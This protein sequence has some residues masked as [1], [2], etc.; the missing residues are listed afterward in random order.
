MYMTLSTKP[1]TLRRRK[2]IFLI[3]NYLVM[4]SILALGSEVILRLKGVKALQKQAPVV[5]VTPGGKFFQSHPVLGYTHIPGRF[6]ISFGSGYSFKVTHLPNTLRVTHPLESY[7]EPVTKKGVWIF[8]CSITH[9]WSLNDEET[10]PWIL[11]ERFPEYEVVN[12]GVSGYG[13]IHSLF[14]FKDALDANTPK[15]A[16]LAYGSF[17]D[18]RN[19]FLRRRRED[20]SLVNKL[21]PLGQPMPG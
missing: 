7:Q 19:T 4:I 11:Q 1:Q 2:K 14:Q 17:H 10:Y 16:I 15:V 18:Q 20:I 21:G 6:N 9:G 12:F 8:G 13:T 5:T 3:T